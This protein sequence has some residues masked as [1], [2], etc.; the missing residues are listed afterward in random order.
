[1]RAEV[2]YFA[3]EVCSDKSVMVAL[4]AELSVELAGDQGAMKGQQQL[5]VWVQGL[6]GALGGRGPAGLKLLW[7]AKWPNGVIKEVSRKAAIAHLVDAD[8]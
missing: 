7:H 4:S 8:G 1:M 2:V 3:R 5:G 6:H